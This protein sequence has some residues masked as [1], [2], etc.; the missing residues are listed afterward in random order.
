MT[1]IRQKKEFDLIKVWGTGLS[2]SAACAAVAGIFFYNQVVNNSHEMAQRRENLR[3]I[4]VKNAEL[5]GALYAL[6]DSQHVQEFAVKK[7]LVVEK[8]PNYVKRQSLSVNL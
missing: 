6:S 2:I 8:N 5:K 3:D 7:N 4:E 1:I